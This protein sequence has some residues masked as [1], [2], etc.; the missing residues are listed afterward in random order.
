MA[1]KIYGQWYTQFPIWVALLTCQ[2]TNLPRMGRIMPVARRPPLEPEFRVPRLFVTLS[3]YI[4]RHVVGALLATLLVIMGL[5]LLLDFIELMRRAAGSPDATMGVLLKMALLKMPQMVQQ[6]LPF[7]VLIGGMVA[8]WRLTRSHELVV[9]RSVGVSIWQFLA[10]TML[11]VGG[12]GV[13]N[14]A[15]LNPVAAAMFKSYQQMEDSVIL[16]RPGTFNI[17]ENGLWLREPRPEGGHMVVRAGHVRQ[18]GFR[19]DMRDLSFIQIDQGERF[20]QRI[21][22][23]LGTLEE[24][25]FRLSDVWIMEPR[26]PG[27]RVP[28][29]SLPTTLTLGRVQENFASPE[30]ISFWELPQFI[31]FFEAAGFSAHS[32]RLHWHSLLAS[33]LL[34]CAMVL[35]AAVFSVSPN[36]R[37]GRGMVRVIGGVGAGFLLYFFTRLTLA[38]GLSATLP[39][40]L[41][42]WSPTV[43]TLLLGITILLHLEDG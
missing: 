41:A 31:R 33:P 35:L 24:G 20:V 22:A 37:S 28:T 36:Q 3:A 40:W 30:T 12:L 25:R 42:A 4:S 9:M 5:I 23:R 1:G 38:L 15:A 8:M 11:V 43:I 18:D 6:V 7:A 19:L 26:Q 29:M 10:P 2:G 16:R 17:S 32:H 14:V 21:D 27:R 13:L 34:L 39:P